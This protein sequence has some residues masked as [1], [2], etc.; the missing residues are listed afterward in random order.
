MGCCATDEPVFKEKKA[1]NHSDEDGH[2]HSSGKDSILKMFLPA[3]ISL[4]LLLFAI[5]YNEIEEFEKNIRNNIEN[6]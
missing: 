1:D 5:G 3:I 2:D 4:V 6:L